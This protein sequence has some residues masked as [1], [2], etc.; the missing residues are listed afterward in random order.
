MAKKERKIIGPVDLTDMAYGGEAVGRHEGMVL[1]VTGGV[2]GDVVNVDVT[3]S[4]K[5]FVRGNVVEVLK[6]SE[7]RTD[8]PCR[9]FGSCGGCQWQNT[10][11]QEQLNI[12]HHLVVEAFQRIGR[13]EVEVQPVLGM[14]DPWHYRNTMEFG[15]AHEREPGLRPT[16]GHRIVPIRECLISRPEINETLKLIWDLITREKLAEILPH[17]A[18]VRAGDTSPGVVVGLF[19]HGEWPEIADRMIEA[20]PDLI[21]GVV[22]RKGRGSDKG[23]TLVGK[24]YT[25]HLL[26]GKK[27]RA[28]IASFF[29]VNRTQV[30]RLL[31]TVIEWLEPR[32]SEVILDAYSGV[33][34]FTLQLAEKVM[35]IIAVEAS[36]SANADAKMNASKWQNIRLVEGNFGEVELPVEKVDGVVIDPPRAGCTPEAVETLVNLS[37]AR[38]VYVSCDPTTLAR[39]AGLLVEAGYHL[40]RVQ[41]VDLFPHTYHVETVALFI[42]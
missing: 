5:S 4:K 39:D 22:Q 30:E 13:L 3:L 8:A 6:P 10:R 11:Y 28:S 24:D 26:L 36:L 14:D 15:F 19:G 29:Q 35:E 37:P 16:R 40:E 1:F 34:T 7:L 25:E 41:P 20:R 17:N 42:R 27:Y 33:G 32:P 9:Y 21:A 12:K 23:R 31:E 38:I 18:F 2:P